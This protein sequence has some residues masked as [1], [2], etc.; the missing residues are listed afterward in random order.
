MGRLFK[1][2]LTG[3][4]TVS[5]ALSIKV[6]HHAEK[7]LLPAAWNHASLAVRAHTKTGSEHIPGSRPIEQAFTEASPQS[8]IRRL[9][10]WQLVQTG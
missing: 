2:L 9:Q 6:T 5:S 10:S 4:M 7:T 8:L 3:E 1:K